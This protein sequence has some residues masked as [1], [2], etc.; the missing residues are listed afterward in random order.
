MYIPVC[1]RYLRHKLI[2]W[3]VFFRVT[4]G[5]WET[6]KKIMKKFLILLFVGS[7]YSHSDN[8]P[9]S[10]S[11]DGF[12]LT[13]V[14]VSCSTRY[15]RFNFYFHFFLFEIFILVWTFQHLFQFWLFNISVSVL[16]FRY[17]YFRF[18]F[19][20]ILLQFGLFNISISVLT[21]W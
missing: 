6:L 2:Q 1:V 4:H 5:F 8:S 15:W 11:N 10:V 20:I 14:L 13:F 3:D 19:S 7:T 18:D 12:C 21:F 16:T 9:I 17:F